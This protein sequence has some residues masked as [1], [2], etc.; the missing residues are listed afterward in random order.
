MFLFAPCNEPGLHPCQR[1]DQ[2][3]RSPP[4]QRGDSLSTL[5][6]RTQAIPATLKVTLSVSW[7]GIRLHFLKNTEPL[8]SPRP[9]S[10]IWILIL[11]KMSFSAAARK[12]RKSRFRGGNGGEGAEVVRVQKTHLSQS[13]DPDGGTGARARKWFGLFTKNDQ[14]SQR[15]LGIQNRCQL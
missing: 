7:G 13:P 2:I 1:G 14:K 8:S 6:C 12:F 3:V 11:G 15:T 9:R 10:P 4:C 5:M